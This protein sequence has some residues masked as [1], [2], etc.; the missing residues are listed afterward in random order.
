MD[1]PVT[2]P[3]KLSQATKRSRIG[4][5]PNSS[6]STWVLGKWNRME[7][8]EKDGI[9]IHFGSPIRANEPADKPVSEKSNR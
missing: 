7:E 9:S 6:P 2:T 1:G 8:K 5:W 3:K 4:N